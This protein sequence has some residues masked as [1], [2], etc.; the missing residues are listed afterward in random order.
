L[1][2]EEAKFKKCVKEVD[3]VEKMCKESEQHIEQLKSTNDQSKIKLVNR[4][5]LLVQKYNDLKK[6]KLDTH[7]RL[8]DLV[9]N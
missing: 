9:E 3:R 4:N 6:K 5:R 1:H 2:E 8:E 7:K